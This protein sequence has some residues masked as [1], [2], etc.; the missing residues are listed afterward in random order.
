MLKPASVRNTVPLPFEDDFSYP[1]PDPDPD[2]W[3][4]S[5]A[6]VN[7][8]FPINPISY[9]VATL[10]GLNGFGIPYDTTS[11]NFNAVGPADTLTSMPILMGDHS[12]S[13][14]IYFSFFYQ[15]GGLGDVPNSAFYNSTNF[16]VPFGDSLVLEF[17]DN[18]GNWDNIGH[19]MEIR[20]LLI[21]L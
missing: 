2:L 20:F 10:D 15:P 3:Q 16:N 6:L 4:N 5:G 21:I 19:E 9:G 7:F 13:E 17:K 14:S 12:P 18:T 1:G 8:T 11:F